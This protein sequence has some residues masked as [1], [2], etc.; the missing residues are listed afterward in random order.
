MNKILVYTEKLSNRSR[1]IF[2]L[3]FRELLGLEVKITDNK[4][5]FISSDLPKLS[6]AKQSLA[7]ELFF[8][9]RNLLF[10]TG[11]SEQNISVFDWEGNK[12]FFATGKTSS[13]P[14][15]LFAAGF[16]LV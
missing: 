5:E 9:S 1:F 2:R 13:L 14:F 12:V 8:Y 6:Y 11:I 3:Y 15:D 7:G 10:E 4:D 16:Y